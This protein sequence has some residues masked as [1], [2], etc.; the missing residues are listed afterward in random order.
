MFLTMNF[1]KDGEKET[2]TNSTAY[3]SPSRQLANQCVDGNRPPKITGSNLSNKITY[4]CT[5]CLN[6][7]KVKST[8]L[9]IS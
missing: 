9:F 8:L 3:N 4:T 7:P 5:S 2:N 1:I 6:P